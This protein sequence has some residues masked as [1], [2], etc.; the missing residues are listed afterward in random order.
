MPWRQLKFQLRAADAP[1]MEQLLIDAGAQAVTLLDAEDQPVFQEEPGSTPL[2]DNTVVCALFAMDTDPEP[3]LA[4]LRRQIPQQSLMH[5]SIEVLADQDWKTAWM[6]DFHPLQFGKR[7]W[8][9]PSWT[10]PPRPDQV[11]V[12]LDPGL[13][14]GTG[15]HP[16]TALCLEWLDQA[17]VVDK[18][19]VDY[20]CGSGVLGIAALLLG[21]QEVW[22]V[23]ND[24]QALTATAVN[25]AH[26]GIAEERL[27]VYAPDAMPAVQ[28]DILLANILSAPLLQLAP[29]F[30]ELLKPGGLLVMSGLIPAQTDALL[31]RCTPWFAMETPC[32]RDGWVRLCGRRRDDN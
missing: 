15:T 20:G 4:S 31:I 22:A 30:A 27:R 24:P 8:I 1:T 5:S 12:M 19:V 3:L 9:C 29:L 17:T 25:R 11:N 26:N 6:A 18:T 2:W 32:E 23:D 14:F 28:A 10:T 13:A 16:T 21:A 7:L